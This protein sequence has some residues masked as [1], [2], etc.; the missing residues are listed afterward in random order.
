MYKKL[1]VVGFLIIVLVNIF[2]IGTYTKP[3]ETKLSAFVSYFDFLFASSSSVAQLFVQVVIN[4]PNITIV[5]PANSTYFFNLSQD[6]IIELNVSADMTIQTWW[7][8]LYNGSGTTIYSDQTFT[9]NTTI[10]AITGTNK[11][12]VYANISGGQTGNTNVTFSTSV[13]GSTPQIENLSSQI[14]ACEDSY[15][16]YIFNIT[17][18]DLEEVSVSITPINPFFITKVSQNG[19]LTKAEIFSG[20]LSKSQVG[21]YLENISASDGTRADTDTTNITVV[22]VNHNPKIE[23]IGAQTIWFN[24]QFYKQIT[25]N[26]TEDGNVTSQN[27]SYNIT[28]NSQ[29]TTFTINSALGIINI[30]ANTSVVGLYNL[31]VCV[32]DR[33]LNTTLYPNASY[34]GYSSLGYNCTTFQLTITNQN[35]APNITSFYPTNQ[36]INE[37]PGMTLT[38][39]VSTNDPDETTPSAYWYVNGGLEQSLT[40]QFNKTFS[41]GG[42]FNV[43]VR[44]SDGELNDSESWTII[45]SNPP[46]GIPSGGG[47]GGGGGGA[48]NERWAC[49]N[50][51]VCQSIQGL[52]QNKLLDADSR[53][54]AE[55]NCREYGW[56]SS[57]CGIKLLDCSDLNKCQTT[58]KKP[59]STETCF[60]VANPSCNDKVKNCHDNSCEVLVDCGGPCSQCPTCSDGLQNQGEEGIDCGGPCPNSCKIERPRGTNYLLYLLILLIIILIVAIIYTIYRLFIVKKRIEESQK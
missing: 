58:R 51:G 2:W 46:R 15:L 36:T 32:T 25:A 60:Y 37:N 42:T 5:S 35:R 28:S 29:N 39:N 44:V 30:T 3:Q 23:L 59:L 10:T 52:Y 26:D 53:E 41:D 34:C 12:A 6:K 19:N 47:G 48:C 21:S 17:D 7:Y 27:L 8:T 57:D 45:V 20:T 1:V 13:T 14:L 55:K 4:A 50:T 54:A 49:D 56:E 9:P 40:N 24:G 33:G 31:S 18:A 22:P 38:F 43:S 16:S 11:L